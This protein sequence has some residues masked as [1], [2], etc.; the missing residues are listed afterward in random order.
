MTWTNAVSTRAKIH[1]DENLQN[2]LTVYKRHR[3]GISSQQSAVSSSARESNRRR[4]S[5][6]FRLCAIRFLGLTPEAIQ[7]AAAPQPIAVA[8]VAESPIVEAYNNPTNT[9]RLRFAAA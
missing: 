4:S 2:V 5:G 3:L 9:A 6:A 7:Y 8:I 1:L